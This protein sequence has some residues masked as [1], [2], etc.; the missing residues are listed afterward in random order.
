MDSQL[1]KNDDGENIKC[2]SVHNNAIDKL[3]FSLNMVSSYTYRR[4]STAHILSS[5]VRYHFLILQSSP[6]PIYRNE[7]PMQIQ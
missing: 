7:S 2:S 3:T 5:I 1:G 4:N 6:C